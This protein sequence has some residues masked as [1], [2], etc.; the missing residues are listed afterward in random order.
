M[1]GDLITKKIS[2]RITT[3]IDRKKKNVEL[4]VT[5]IRHRYPDTYGLRDSSVSTHISDLLGKTS[6]LLPQL[7]TS[8]STNHLLPRTL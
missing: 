1:A 5:D 2:K 4:F 8:T 6:R 3:A 7:S